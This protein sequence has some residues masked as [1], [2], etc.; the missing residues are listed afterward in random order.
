[1]TKHVSVIFIH[2]SLEQV[3]IGI[4]SPEFTRQYFHNT[5][6]ESD[7]QAGSPVTFYNQ[8]KSIAVA[9]EVIE[10]RPSEFLRYS[11][12]VRYNPAATQEKP[13]RVT[14]E[15]ET[16]NDATKLTVTHDEFPDNSVVYPQITEGWIA[17]LCNLKTLL[18][19]NKVMAI[20]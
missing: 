9:G 14:F 15:L 12:H 4:T 7:W 19:T 5:D 16:K 1:M 13:S 2:A 18:E 3:W 10:A 20:S 8:D 17:I 6:I 11:W